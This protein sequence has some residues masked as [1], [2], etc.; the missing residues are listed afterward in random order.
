MPKTLL[1]WYGLRSMFAL[2]RF[3]AVFLLALVLFTSGAPARGM[4]ADGERDLLLHERLVE[5]VREARAKAGIADPMTLDPTLGVAA[6]D[7]ARDM[8]Q[9]GYF[10]HASPDGLNALDRVRRYEPYFRGMLG[11]NLA[12]RTVSGIQNMDLDLI[13]ESIMTAWLKS[14]GHRATL[15]SRQ[16]TFTGIGVAFSGDTVYVTQLFAAPL[17]GLPLSTAGKKLPRR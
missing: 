14:P 17:P 10:A 2:R 6:G 8:A 13:V 3:P 4:A 12:Y 1:G 9:R 11:E 16:F 5:A 7:H 15:L